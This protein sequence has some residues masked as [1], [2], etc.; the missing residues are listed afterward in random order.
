ML[1]SSI[2]FSL[3]VHPL[4]AG[5]Q[6]EAEGQVGVKLGEGGRKEGLPARSQYR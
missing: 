3:A 4:L 5:V 2:F 6:G 1:N